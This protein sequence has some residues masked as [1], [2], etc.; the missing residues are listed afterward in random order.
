[1]NAINNFANQLES[2]PGYGMAVDWIN[3]KASEKIVTKDPFYE[4]VNGKKKRRH[5]PDGYTK[6]ESK[7][8]K[9][10]RNRAWLDDKNFCGCYPVNLGV[11]LAPFLAWLP[12]IGPF[13]MY[14][15]HGR[16]IEIA[17]KE[18]HLPP[19]SVAKMHGNIIFDLLISLP[20]V[21][22]SLFSWMNSC[23]TRNAAIIH[24]FMSREIIE[25]NKREQ[26]EEMN[27]KSPFDNPPQSANSKNYRG[28]PP[29]VPSRSY[30]PAN[31]YGR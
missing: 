25:R 1:M 12:V 2:I 17:N 3:D 18:L 19:E 20:P 22:G 21:L 26:L 10:V 6:Q 16:L 4:E 27:H 28:H 23:S 30:Q 13:I 14:A 7:T 15:I 8:W 5:L 11:G 31:N 29:K 9:K 24:T